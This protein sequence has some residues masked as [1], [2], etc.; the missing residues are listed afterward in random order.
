MAF[1]LSSLF[2]WSQSRRET[3]SP[4]D[5]R[6]ERRRESAFRSDERKERRRDSPYHA[7]SVT[8]GHPSCEAAK[9]LGTL[10]FLAGQAPSLPLAGCEVRPCECRYSHF[11]DRR[12]GLDRRVEIGGMPPHGLEERRHNHG[13]RAGDAVR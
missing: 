10:R 11:S 9:Q 7:V 4:L 2:P 6:Q 13:R 5:Q 3:A 12:T 8:A 1:R